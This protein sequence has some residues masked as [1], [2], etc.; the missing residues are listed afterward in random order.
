VP[1]SLVGA[2]SRLIA[3]HDTATDGPEVDASGPDGAGEPEDV[4]EVREGE[5]GVEDFRAL[6]ADGREGP[7]R[8]C[9]V[10]DVLAAQPDVRVSYSELA[11]GTGLTEMELRGGLAGLT[12]FC[13]ERWPGQGE[14]MRP[15]RKTWARTERADTIGEAQYT[16]PASHARRWLRA[17]G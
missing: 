11:E 4:D 2:V 14:R 12:W 5:W 3:D 10:L 13:N 17:R 16:L 1:R 9:R 6:I 8:A 7:A 15:M